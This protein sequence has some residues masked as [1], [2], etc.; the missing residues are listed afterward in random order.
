MAN[1]FARTEKK[2]ILNKEQYL[3]LK[4]MLN[5]KIIEEKFFKYKICNIYYDTDN[6]DLFR[7][8]IDK[9]IYKEKLRLRSY[10]TP[11]LEDVVFLEIK[12]K[13]KGVVYKRRIDLEL[14]NIY[15]F[16]KN[17]DLT[18]YDNIN[19][20]EIRYMLSRYDLLPRVY[21]SYDREAYLWKNDSDFR[22]TFDTNIKY[23][24]DDVCLEK[25]DSGEN[26]LDTDTYIMEV[27]CSNNL[28]LDFVKILSELKIYPQSFSKIGTVYKNVILGGQKCSQY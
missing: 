1:I 13:Y 18:F 24:M 25:G 19:E 5:E 12:K 8:S 20:K 10:G 15:E 23:R 26:I 7:L 4:E 22:I 9:P 6:F 17:K 28:P 3:K 11:N 2:Y 14:K 21:L 16:F 27:K